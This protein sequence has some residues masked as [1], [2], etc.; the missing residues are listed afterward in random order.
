MTECI[1]QQH[2]LQAALVLVRC[3]QTFEPGWTDFGGGIA[4]TPKWQTTVNEMGEIPVLEEDGVRLTQT[5]PILLQLAN[6]YGRFGGNSAQKFEILQWLFWDNHKLPPLSSAPLCQRS[7]IGGAGARPDHP[8][9]TGRPSPSCA[10][11]P[12]RR[13]R[14]WWL[15]IAGRSRGR[16]PLSG[17]QQSPVVANPGV[18]ERP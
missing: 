17:R 4:H 2:Q 7:L 16:G 14:R 8:Y 10:R 3:G 6:R 12:D 18:S 1:S 5:A 11:G 13:S 9:R 15:S